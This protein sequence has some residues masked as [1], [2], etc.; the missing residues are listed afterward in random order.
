MTTIENTAFSGCSG[1]T[2][3]SIPNSVAFI[4]E[5][6]FAYCSG[7]EQIEVEPGNTVYDSRNNCNAIIKTDTNELISGCMNS[8]IP[9]SVTAIGNSAFMVVTV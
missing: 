8:F 7:L 1:L 4:G 3:L 2:S 6:P 9:N 5:N